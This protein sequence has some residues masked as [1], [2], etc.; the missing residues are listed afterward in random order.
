[1]LVVVAAV[2][3]TT[4]CPSSRQLDAKPKPGVQAIV[5]RGTCLGEFKKGKDTECVSYDGGITW[6]CGHL[7][8]AIACYEP[9]KVP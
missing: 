8:T 5:A 4:G 2:T 6:T 3:L 9:K 7:K 1:M